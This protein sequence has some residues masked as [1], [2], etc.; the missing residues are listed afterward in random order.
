MARTVS[1]SVSL[2]YPGFFSPFPH[3]TGCAIGDRPCLALSSGLDGFTRGSTCSVLLGY[4]LKRLG[5]RPY[6]AVT[7][8]GR[9]FQA[10]PLTSLPSPFLPTS[11]S[12]PG[13]QLEANR[14]RWPHDPNGRT[15]WFRLLRVRSP[16]LAESLRFLF[17]RLL[18]CF[19]SPGSLLIPYVFRKG[20]L[21]TTP[22]GFPHSGTPGSTLLCSS[23]GRFAAYAPF[24]GNLSLGIHRTAS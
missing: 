19:S 8:C 5:F 7:R 10:V 13:P 21:D 6:G 14:E 1:G 17:L 9:P 24:F 23:P 16:L 20:S 3:G 22:G 2:P 15:H 12:G 4:P 11:S 18:R